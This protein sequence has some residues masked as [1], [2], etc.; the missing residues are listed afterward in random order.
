MIVASDGPSFP[1]FRRK[2]LTEQI[3]C[4]LGIGYFKAKQAFFR[5]TNRALDT[6]TD[7]G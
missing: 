3:Y 7:Q 4:L 5:K 6:T 2:G 1:A